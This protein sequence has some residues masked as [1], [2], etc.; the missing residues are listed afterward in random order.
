[1][2]LKDKA[3]VVTGGGSGIGRAMANLYAAEG[4][5]VLVADI[6]GDAVEETLAEIKKA[7]GTASG[8]V[9]DVSKDADVCKMIDVAVSTFD[10]LDVLCNN[11]GVLDR[12]TPAADVTDALW[13]KVLGVNLDGVFFACRKAIPIMIERGGGSRARCAS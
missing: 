1:M 6:V 12:L 7:G 2:R 4:A 8:F 5:R 10:R 9:G 11:A 13:E 3:V